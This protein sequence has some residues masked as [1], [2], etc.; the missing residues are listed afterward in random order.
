MEQMGSPRGSRP[1]G[2][3]AP[4]GSRGPRGFWG[5]FGDDADEL[6]DIC[7]DNNDNIDN[8]GEAVAADYYNRIWKVDDQH[9]CILIS[10][11]RS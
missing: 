5:A 4:G 11:E 9:I 1:Q 7:I 8:D 6:D 2:Y 3:R 10:G